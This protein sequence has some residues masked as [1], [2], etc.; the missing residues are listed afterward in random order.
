MCGNAYEQLMSIVM[1]LNEQTSQIALWR[2]W[3]PAEDP[4]TAAFPT[5]SHKHVTWCDGARCDAMGHDGMRIRND[6]AMGKGGIV[7]EG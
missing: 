2:S 3:P 4:P 6:G 7:W 5:A 1:I